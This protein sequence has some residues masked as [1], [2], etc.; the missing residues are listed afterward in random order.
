M[1][2]KGQISTVINASLS[3]SGPRL[4]QPPCFW[5]ALRLRSSVS[6]RMKKDLAIRALDIAVRLRQPPKGCIFLSDRGSS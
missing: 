5:L 4:A 2:L 6:D 1:P 3:G